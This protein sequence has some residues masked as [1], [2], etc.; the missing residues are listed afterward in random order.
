MTEEYYKELVAKRGEE[1]EKYRFGSKDMF[2]FTTQRGGDSNL[3]KIGKFNDCVA[4]Y[5]RAGIAKKFCTQYG[6]PKQK[7]YHSN[8]HGG[9][10]VP[11][12]LV[13][14]WTRVGHHYCPVWHS[15]G[16]P[17]DYIFT[18][19]DVDGFEKCLNFHE[20]I[21]SLDVSDKAYGKGG[22][23]VNLLPQKPA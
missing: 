4:M 17:K 13:Q 22:E 5:A 18:Q 7:P 2:F 14:E 21:I 15:H 3:G 23:I 1:R 6:F 8:Q 19:E 11:N 16:R 10:V 9:A 20:W 12:I